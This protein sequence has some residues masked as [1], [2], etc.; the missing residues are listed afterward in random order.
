VYHEE[1]GDIPVE[2]WGKLVKSEDFNANTKDLEAERKTYNYVKRSR[3][4]YGSYP[5]MTMMRGSTWG[6]LLRHPRIA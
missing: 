5:G 3:E 4:G 1:P 2:N 6:M